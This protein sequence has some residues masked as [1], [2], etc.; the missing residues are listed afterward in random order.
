MAV[1]K[2]KDLA[3][4]EALDYLKKKE[5]AKLKAATKLLNRKTDEMKIHREDCIEV[6]NEFQNWLNA[7]KSNDYVVVLAK[8]FYN[9]ISRVEMNNKRLKSIFANVILEMMNWH[10]MLFDID[11]QQVLK[12]LLLLAISKLSL[13]AFIAYWS[14]NLLLKKAK[15]LSETLCSW[16]LEWSK[17][18]QTTDKQHW[19][20]FI[21]QFIPSANFTANSTSQTCELFLR[22]TIEQ[23]VK[24]EVETVVVWNGN[25]DGHVLG[26]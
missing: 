16:V 5:K 9:W 20:K 12:R 15:I 10:E 14:S 17:K 24:A 11:K 7:E 21:E 6:I 23:P 22:H 25:G 8:A 4:L 2:E 1:T 3:V 26:S 19:E 18:G 13:A